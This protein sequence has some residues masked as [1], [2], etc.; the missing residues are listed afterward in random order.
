M[1]HPEGKKEAGKARL[2]QAAGRGFRTNGYGGV[3]IDGLAK[4]ANATSGAFYAHFTSKADAFK[5]AVESGLSD[6]S[7]GVEG[8]IAAGGDGWLTQFIDF[9][10]G[11][12]R[13]CDL[14]ESCALQSL[15]SEVARADV[16]TRSVY[17]AGFEDVLGVMTDGMMGDARRRNAIALLAM[18]TG[19][20]SLSRAV[21]DPDLAGEIA[22]AVREAARALLQSTENVEK[23]N[24]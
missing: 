21:V 5:Q 7:A 24:D 19:G 15:T 11:D 18:L 16:P 13:T 12:R 3:G 22:D 17:Q 4:Q 23:S 20:V 1:A 8:K 9:Y 14:A 2:L 10:M 6:L